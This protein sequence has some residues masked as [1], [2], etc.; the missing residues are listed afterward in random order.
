MA[1]G[2]LEP[3]WLEPKCHHRL[4]IGSSWQTHNMT[5]WPMTVWPCDRV[6]VWPCDHGHAVIGHAVI[7][8]L[9]MR[10]CHV[11]VKNSQLSICDDSLP[12]QA[13][14]FCVLCESNRFILKKVQKCACT[15]RKKDFP[16]NRK[17]RCRCGKLL[18]RRQETNENIATKVQKCIPNI[19]CDP[20]YNRIS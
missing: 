20:N 16:A 10:S 18:S 14:I 4:I 12:V 9:A 2:V 6:T 7:R 17:E 5:A 3:K 11:F 15:W 13:P 8:S 1:T 19:Q